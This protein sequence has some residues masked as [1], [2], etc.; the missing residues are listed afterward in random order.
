MTVKEVMEKYGA[1]YEYAIEESETGLIF[2]PDCGG[3]LLDWRDMNRA[4]YEDYA[5]CKAKEVD[6]DGYREEKTILIVV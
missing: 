2:W 5:D 3:D 4:T 1:K 6:V